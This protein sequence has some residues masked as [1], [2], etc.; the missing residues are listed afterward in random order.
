[1][2]IVSYLKWCLPLLL[3]EWIQR[4]GKYAMDLQQWL[5]TKV[6]KKDKNQK[7]NINRIHISIK[8]ILYVVLGL[9]IYFFHKKV[10]LA[11]YYYFKF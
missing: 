5:P 10:N 9:S 2:Y 3:V 11:E 7:R 1:M 6:T 4:K 8:I